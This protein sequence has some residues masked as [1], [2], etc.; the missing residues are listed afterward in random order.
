VKNKWDPTNFLRHNQNIEPR[1]GS[2][3]R[4]PDVASRVEA[5]KPR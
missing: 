1:Q 3:R 4:N 2:G 5:V